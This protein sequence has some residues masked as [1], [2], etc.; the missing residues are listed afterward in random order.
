ML[1]ARARK[2]FG[3]IAA[4]GSRSFLVVL[5]VAIG[6]FAF[7]SVLDARAILVREPDSNYRR[8]NPSAAV[9][10]LAALPE[11]A[12]PLTEADLERIIGRVEGIMDVS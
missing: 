8:T 10:E 11:E 6:V 5:A 1:D 2:V 3:D 7:G 9:L 4:E 12:A